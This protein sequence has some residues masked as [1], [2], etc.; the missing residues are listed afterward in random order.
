LSTISTCSD[1]INPPSVGYVKDFVTH[2]LTTKGISVSEKGGFMGVLVPIQ[3]HRAVP[4]ATG[5]PDS[6]PVDIYL[7]RLAP[8]SRRGIVVALNTISGHLSNGTTDAYG[9]DWAGLRYQQTS[10]VRQYLARTYSPKT[11]NLCI[12]ALRG[13]LKE[14][15]RLG[16]IENDE[17]QRAIDLRRVVEENGV[18]GRAL[19]VDE[20]RSLFSVCD[21]DPSPAGPRDA[22]LIAVL[23]CTGMRRNEAVGLRTVDYDPK[24]AAF[25]IRGKGNKV[26]LAFLTDDAQNRLTAWLKVRGQS[27][28]PLF[29]SVDK[30]G[31][32]GTQPLRG[33]SIRYILQ[34]R[35]REAGV[36]PFSPHSMRRTMATHLLDRGVDL[37]IVQKML[38]H[39]HLSTT[40]LY[41]RRG[42]AE[43]KRAAENLR[44]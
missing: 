28:G 27:V 26:R 15:W 19:G 32:L 25:K 29:V 9:F 23:Y 7:G 43:K 31:M 14:C 33:Q 24:Q 12:S 18:G 20:L 4:V 5:R 1:V 42:E 22:A 30:A 40:A 3:Q 13:V 16:L 10:A 11:T 36:K 44:V 21:A 41:D 8:G 34:S 37:A 17:Y 6:N 39:R 2:S 35:A 38:G